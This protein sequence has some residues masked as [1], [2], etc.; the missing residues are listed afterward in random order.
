M[1]HKLLQGVVLFLLA[2]VCL[3]L[4]SAAQD[5][6][7]VVGTVTDVSGAAIPK[8]K[9]TISNP[10]RGFVR[11][12]ITSALGEYSAAKIPIGQYEITAEAAGFEKLIRTGITLEVG[13]TLRVNLQLI[14][15]AVTQSIFVQGNVPKVETQTAA[16]S[17]VITGSQISN[18]MLNGRNFTNLALLVPGAIPD[19]SYDPTAIGYGGSANISFNGGRMDYTTWE[20]DGATT[21]D[22][23][24]DSGTSL[25]TYPSVDSIAEF[26]VL[27]SNYGAET[28]KNSTT[29]VEIATKSGTRTFHGDAYDYVRNDSLDAND[30]FANRTIAPPGGNAPKTPLKWNDFGYTLGGPAYIPGHYNTDKSKTFFFWSENWRMYREGTVISS[31]T[32]SLRERQGDFS[33]CDPQSANYNAVVA[34]GCA[35]PVV[36]GVATDTVPVDPNAAAIIGSYFPLPD[37]G[38]DGYLAAHSLPTNWREDQIRGDQNINEKTSVFV[39]FTHD[40]WNTVETPSS[41][42]SSQ[43]DTVENVYNA[44]AMTGVIHLTENFEPNLMNEFIMGYSGLTYEI[45]PEAGPSSPD[46]SFTKP[47]SWTASNIFAPNSSFTMLP[48]VSI[49]GGLPSCFIEDSGEFSNGADPYR[50]ADHNFNYKDNAAWVKG[51]HTVKFGFLL[52]KVRGGGQIGQVPW[53]NYSFATSSSITTGNGLADMDL[54]RIA[55]YTEGTAAIDGTP[56]GGLG[57]GYWRA[58]DLEPY[59]GDDWMAT[60]KLTINIGVRIMYYVPLHDKTKPT[61]D[62]NFVPNLYNSNVTD[63]LTASG[64]VAADPATGHILDYTQFG[65]GL[66]ECGAP[67]EPVGCLP[68]HWQ[69]SPRFGFAYDPTGH[70]MTVIRGGIGIYGGAGGSYNATIDNMSEGNGSGQPPRILSSADYN[71]NGFQSIQRGLLG[72]L[73]SLTGMP[74]TT[75]Y[76]ST[77]QY[78]FGIQH[79]FPQS[80]LLGVTYVGTQGRHLPRQRNLNQIPDGTTTEQVQV[81]SAPG[82]SLEPLPDPACDANGNCNVQ[83]ILIH[84]RYPNNFF[85]PY[86][87]YGNIGYLEDTAVSSYNALQ[88]D[89][90]HVVGHGLTLQTAYTWSHAIDNNSNLFYLTGVDDSNLGRWRSNSSLN[91]TQVLV[92]D[93]MYDLP[94]FRH[95]S[96]SLAR[97]GLGG[98]QIT[99]ISSFFTGEPIDFGCGVSGYSSGIGEGVRCNSVGSFKIAKGVTNDPQFGPTPTWFDPN[100][101]SQPTLAQLYS[102]GEPG[103]F[104]YMDRNPLTGPGRNNWDM[105]LHK[106]F[107]LPWVGAE[108]STLQFRLETFNTFNHPQWKGVSAGCNGSPNADGTP[109]FG[110]PCGGTLYNLGN[111]EVSGAW[112]P[113]IMQL[114]LKFIF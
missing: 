112:P 45:K 83:D 33:E 26:R 6:A 86:R 111:G 69:A 75:S 8:A 14:V 67:P 21:S 63:L 5:L 38:V 109:A 81:L 25:T 13:Q 1:S 54:G 106:E 55:S 95:A 37:N 85:V 9:V 53:G 43:Y 76:P 102:N 22:D 28:G 77:Y 19:N 108:H 61:Y 93:Y 20:L 10:D 48:W 80:N 39:R 66:L 15:G 44:P 64:N 29:T 3:S 52:E 74:S 12:Q 99:G 73:P 59:I 31:L 34:S 91:R 57:R 101:F 18:T 89:F 72:V 47:A 90:H 88:V 70:G 30:W 62:I 27:T 46:H 87:D 92:V 78:S 65:N 98:W 49:C 16:L 50:T 105:A 17:D 60:K 11:E 94:F 58:T 42:T 7:S 82:G 71:V 23:A 104:G 41:W 100:A 51:K 79:E 113:R 96:N 24:T 97:Q 110:R 114:G 36:N 4:P 56:V 84:N 107:E 32:P 35:L 103:M 68:R 40:G 2:E